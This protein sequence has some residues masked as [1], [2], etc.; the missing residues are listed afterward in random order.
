MK[1]IEEERKKIEEA[2]K[3]AISQLQDVQKNALSWKLHE[4]MSKQILKK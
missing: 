1:E 3:K 2:E 4:E